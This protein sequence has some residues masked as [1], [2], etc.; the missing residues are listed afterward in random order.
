MT[1]QESIEGY[2]TS[3]GR[4]KEDEE[5]LEDGEEM[6]QMEAQGQAKD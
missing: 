1:N 3:S 4:V 6:A 5:Q 2:L